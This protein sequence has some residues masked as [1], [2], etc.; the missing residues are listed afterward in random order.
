MYRS[1]D[2]AGRSRKYPDTLSHGKKEGSMSRAAEPNSRMISRLCKGFKGRL[3]QKTGWGRVEVWR[4]F[5]EALS[6]ALA[7]A[8][9]RCE[10]GIEG[11]DH[12][13]F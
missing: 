11:G 5:Q 6:V 10:Y 8:L 7:N 9:D 2:S 1:R 12:G 4:E 13:D 3:D